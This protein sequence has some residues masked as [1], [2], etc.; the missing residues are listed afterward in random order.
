MIFFSS[1]FDFFFIYLFFFAFFHCYFV[2]Y[3]FYLF[4]GIRFMNSL[5]VGQFF[6]VSCACVSWRCFIFVWFYALFVY[7]TPSFKRSVGLA[8]ARSLVGDDGSLFGAIPSNPIQIFFRQFIRK[9]HSRLIMTHSGKEVRTCKIGSET[10]TGWVW[11]CGILLECSRRGCETAPK[12]NCEA[13]S[14]SDNKGNEK[15]EFIHTDMHIYNWVHTGK[16]E[17][18]TF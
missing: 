4:V 13:E 8:R 7:N 3:S 14:Q 16:E 15:L 10:W 9:K 2:E 17:A 1:W 6:C 18:A 5:L 11:F 12:M